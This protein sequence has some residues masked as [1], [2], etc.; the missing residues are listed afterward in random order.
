MCCSCQNVN[1]NFGSNYKILES[2]GPAAVVLLYDTLNR[3]HFEYH[4]L[5]STATGFLSEE[6]EPDSSEEWNE[7]IWG[8]VETGNPVVLEKKKH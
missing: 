6:T 5:R 4:D 8:T 7:F 1:G 2:R 3:S